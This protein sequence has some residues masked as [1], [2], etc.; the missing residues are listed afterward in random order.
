MR[1]PSNAQGGGS[2]P[3]SIQQMAAHAKPTLIQT[4]TRGFPPKGSPKP[5]K[6]LTWRIFR[7]ERRLCNDMKASKFCQNGGVGF[8]KSPQGER[9]ACKKVTEFMWTA[10]TASE[11]N[12]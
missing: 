1:P 11:L 2:Q 3:C 6:S 8:V 4:P 10:A 7:H 5:E 12:S 9:L